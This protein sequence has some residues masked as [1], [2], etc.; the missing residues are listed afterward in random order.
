MILGTKYTIKPM[1]LNDEKKGELAGYIH[2]YEPIIIIDYTCPKP[3][4]NH[5]LRHEIIHAFK[6]ESGLRTCEVMN[7]EQQVDWMAIQ[8]IKINKVFKELNIL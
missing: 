8:F 4:L 1:K 2:T 5:G 7:D 3:E 6:H